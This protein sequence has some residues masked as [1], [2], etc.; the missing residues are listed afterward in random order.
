[1]IVLKS[2]TIGSTQ[3]R[4]VAIDG[5]E[6]VQANYGDAW[7]TIS[8]VYMSSDDAWKQVEWYENEWN[9]NSDIS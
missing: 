1:M 4:Q 9:M 6:V 3:Y 8:G 2:L 5:Q 7:E